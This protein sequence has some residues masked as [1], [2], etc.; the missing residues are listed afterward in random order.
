M[1]NRLSLHLFPVRNIP[2]PLWEGVGKG[3][4]KQSCPSSFCPPHKGEEIKGKCS[5]RFVRKC[6][7]RYPNGPKIAAC[8]GNPPYSKRDM[9]SKRASVLYVSL[10]ALIVL[11]VLSLALANIVSTQMR[12]SNFFVRSV[13]SLPLAKIAYYSAFSE[14]SEDTKKAKKDEQSE[15]KEIRK[16]DSEKLMLA[17]REKRFEGGL[18]YKYF[19]EDEGSRV[20]INTATAEVLA[21]LPGMDEDLAHTLIDSNLRPFRVKEEILLVEDI[22]PEIFDK[23]KD[24][25]T[26]YGNG[27]ININTAPSEVLLALGLDE[28][29]AGI[30]MS[31]RKGYIGKDGQENTEDDGAF[32]TTDGLLD[33]LREFTM[34]S[35]SQEQ[36]LLSA[37]NVL[38]VKSDI[39]RL[40]VLTAI[41]A[42]S[43]NTYSIVMDPRNKKILSW[44][45][46]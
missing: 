29:L 14:R 25:I 28:E 22:T 7:D 11:S 21:K 20:N 13:V 8:S 16:F 26:V 24:S 4:N 19:F 23:L 1:K 2:L 34:L 38:S 45:E 6:R 31:F 42:R 17:K 3:Y 46:F 12:F 5:D 37:K 15:P 39:V 27:K 44:Q 36:E 9:Q 35:L 18:N 40:K 30:L 43:G 32:T 10:W 41:N 33:Q